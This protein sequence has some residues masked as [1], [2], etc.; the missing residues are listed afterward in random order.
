MQTVLLILSMILFSSGI[1]AQFFGGC[2]A[3]FSMIGCGGY[4]YG[5]GYG[6]YSPLGGFSPYGVGMGNFGV[7]C[8]GFGGFYGRK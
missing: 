7:G 5:F 8:C 2:S 1:N 6:G 4:G 3:G